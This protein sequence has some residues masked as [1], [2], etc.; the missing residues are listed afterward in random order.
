MKTLSLI[1]AFSLPLAVGRPVLAAAEKPPGPAVLVTADVFSDQP[2]A[3]RPT[4]EQP[5]YYYIFDQKERTIG[6]VYAGEKMPSR[7]FVEAEVEKALAGQ[8][9]IRTMVGGVQPSVILMVIFGTANLAADEI[10]GEDG[11]NIFY[12]RREMLQLAGSPKPSDPGYGDQVLEGKVNQAIREDRL[13]VML[14]AFDAAAMA[15]KEK[16][17][18]WRTR[19]SID[20]LRGNLPAALPVM[21]ASAAPYFGRATTVAQF[22][23]DQARRN[24]TVKLAPLQ[25]LD[26]EP[27]AKPAGK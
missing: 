4:P 7:A 15:K 22:V 17:L 14:G 3:F 2:E 19:M 10:P 11:G 21:L 5:V 9:F 20:A 12:N 26:T 18:L 25:I 6:K 27:P 23:D 16:K 1:L 8:G 13:Y 24:P